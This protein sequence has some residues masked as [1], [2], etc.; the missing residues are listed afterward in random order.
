MTR[1]LK[2]CASLA[3]ILACLSVEAAE[4]RLGVT[5]PRG[6]LEVIKQWG[7]L[8]QYLEQQIGSKVTLIPLTPTDSAPAVASG[9]VDY[10]FTNPVLTVVLNK[11]YGATPL[12]TLKRKTGTQFGGVILAKKGSGIRKGSDLKGKKV[13]GFQFRKSAAAYVFQVKQL[14]DEGIDPNKD[15]ASF[16]EAK[17]QDDIVLAVRAGLMDA[18]FVKSGLLEAMAKEGKIKLDEFEIVD[19]KNDGYMHVHSTILYPEWY[20]NASSAADQATSEKVK[21]ALL[22]IMPNDTVAVSGRCQGFVP[23]LSLDDLDATMKAL[24]LGPYDVCSVAGNP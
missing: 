12:A 18:G 10:I 22:K 2:L 5:A 19:Q 23:P 14:M 24:K 8:G 17:K 1:L 7:P 15:F 11:K 3:L 20:V 21:A 4:I 9:K 16:T 13:M 6:A